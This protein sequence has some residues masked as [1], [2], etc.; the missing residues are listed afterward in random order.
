MESL[1]RKALH[2]FAIGQSQ[3]CLGIALSGGKDSLTLL[4]LLARI[5]GQ[6]V[7]WTELRAFHVKGLYSCG[8]GVNEAYLQ[9]VCKKVQVPLH[10]LETPVSSRPLECYSCSRMRRSLL[11]EGA[12]QRGIS[13]LAFGHHREDS[14]ETLLLN[15]L[16]KAEFAAMLPKVPM[17]KY[18]V[19]ILR[20]LLYISEGDIISFAKQKGFLRLL[21][22]C[23]RSATSKRRRTKE[24]LD[25]LE[26]EF[27]H[28]RQNLAQASQQY[29]AK[30]ALKG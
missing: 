26:Q 15:L 9:E 1:V 6:G 13:Q 5:R 7:D 18:N 11:F 22:Q 2:D 28:A 30:K 23:P 14:I 16:H 12:K 19:T 8:A 25:V 21:C 3:K 27:P 20:P 29:G 24:L 10:I 4:H 17:E